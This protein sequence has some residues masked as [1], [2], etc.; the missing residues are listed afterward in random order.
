M[1]T[2]RTQF[3]TTPPG[4]WKNRIIYKKLKEGKRGRNRT[5]EPFKAKDFIEHEK[6]LHIY[7]ERKLMHGIKE[8]GRQQTT[9]TT[10]T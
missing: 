3:L 8:Q 1:K 2:P 9:Q 7:K 4:T 6:I 10:I 5:K